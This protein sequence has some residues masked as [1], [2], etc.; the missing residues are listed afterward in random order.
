MALVVAVH[1]A[2]CS[3]VRLG[4]RRV[5]ELARAEQVARNRVAYERARERATRLKRGMAPEEVEAAMGGVIAVED[6]PRGEGGRQKL[7]EGLLCVVE[8][9]PRRQR[10]LFGYDEDNVVLVGFALDFERESPESE[11]WLVQRIDQAPQEECRE[12]GATPRDASRD[13]PKRVDL[14]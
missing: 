1:V 5:P 12:P 4:E 8:V 14:R 6:E 10:W 13:H 9:S 7:V 3:G 2:A 11:D